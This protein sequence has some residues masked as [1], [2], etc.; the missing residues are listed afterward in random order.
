MHFWNVGGV[1]NNTNV[2][3]ASIQYTKSYHAKISMLI[4]EGRTNKTIN[5]SNDVSNNICFHFASDNSK[6]MSLG[7]PIH[8]QSIKILGIF[9]N[10]FLLK[11]IK[12]FKFYENLFSW[13]I[14][15][16][17]RPFKFSFQKQTTFLRNLILLKLFFSNKILILFSNINFFE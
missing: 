5:K 8:F 2:L 7:F 9:E 11:R 4:G 16:F 15:M 13:S 3:G 1:P 12:I 6:L 14:C 10:L 17:G